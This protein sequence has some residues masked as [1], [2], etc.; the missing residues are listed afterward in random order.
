MNQDATETHATANEDSPARRRSLPVRLLRGLM[1]LALSIVMLVMCGWCALAIHFSNLPGQ[2]LRTGAAWLFVLFWVI[3]FVVLRKRKRT[4]AWFFVSFAAVLAW[5]LLIPASHDRDWIPETSKMPRV[6]IDGDRVTVHNI[7]YFDYRAEEDY[8]VRYV[9]RTYD[10]RKLAT[11]D[12]IGSSWGVK[13]VVHTML[14]FGFG[15]D[16]HLALSVETRREK[17]EPQTMVRS[18]FKQYELIY[19]LAD[20]CDLLRL[21]SNFRKEDLYV[22]PTTT[23][24]AEARVLFMEVVNTVNRLD[25]KA[26][27]YNLLTHNCTT[28]LVPLVRTIRPIP[29][30]FDWRFLLNAYT[31]EMA[32]THKWIDTSLSFTEML[33]ACHVNRYV[34]DHPE[35]EG[36]STRI[37]PDVG[38]V[39]D[40]TVP[41]S[42][43]SGD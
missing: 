14:T 11:V 2:S 33:D 24:P 32:Y 8:D 4:T 27:F 17:G 26:Q 6:E 37:R 1:I 3:A 31:A 12:F 39:T 13:N 18:L 42:G 35:C 15:D 16:G 25:R 38:H 28:S 21:R 10:L 23:T 19:I 36:Y 30:G 40:R 20:E 29:R 5:W 43:L 9:D 7:R 41:R 22:F 34:E